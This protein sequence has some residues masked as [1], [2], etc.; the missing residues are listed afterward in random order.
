MTTS[1]HEAAGPWDGDAWAPGPEP[2]RPADQPAESDLLVHKPAP[3]LSGH[4]WDDPADDWGPTPDSRRRGSA[5]WSQRVNEAAADG[6]PTRA[7]IATI[8]G[9]VAGCLLLD[10][11]L[12]SGRIT[13]FFDLCFVVI[14]LVASLAVRRSD[15]FTAGVLPPLVFAAA[16]AVVSLAH[17][18]ALAPGHGVD[19]A[20]MTGLADHAPGLLGGYAVA[21]L[22][23]AARVA[24]SGIRTR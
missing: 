17:P 22:A 11:A 7:L 16:I 21:L 20:F 18:R 9:V 12:T 13:F 24:T 10:L 14:C 6:L 1:A 15:L 4:E 8:A 2:E 3:S 5:S 23:V 19:V